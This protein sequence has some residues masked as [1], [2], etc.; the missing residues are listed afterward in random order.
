MGKPSAPSA[1]DPYT[2]AQAQY[3]YGT[4]AANYNTALNDMNTVGPT[5]STSYGITGYD[6]STGAPIR[7]Q[8]TTLSPAEQQILNSSQG[9]QQGQLG[10]AGTLLSDVNRTAGAGTPNIAPIQYTAGNAGPVSMSINTSGVTG[11]PTIQ[12]MGGLE[13]GAQSTA[14]AGEEAAMQPGMQQQ[15]EQLDAS[16]RN[17]GAHPGDPA[18]DNA[19]ASFNASMN[20]AQTQAA[21]AAI[22]AG[23]GL[24]NT[25]YGEE[26]NSNQQLFSEA[27]AQ[28][29]AE[30]AAQSQ[31]FGEGATNA[32]LS[33]SAGTTALQDWANETGIP[34]NE[35]SAILGGSQ[36]QAPSSIAPTASQVSAP[37]IMSAFQNQYAGQLSGYNANV[38][39]QNAMIGDA[40]SLGALAYLAFA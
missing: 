35:L 21:G 34:L 11:L 32:N 25:V 17:S 31:L 8:T 36:V 6:P 26:A 16:L 39:S 22:T 12:G 30:N 4:E 7:S 40:T 1:P 37:D 10:T 19:M 9:I 2:T 23:T 18:Y 5:G 33:N 27:Q 20:N 3:Q 14:L 13:Q 28:Q 38:A 15:Y 24:E 29:Q